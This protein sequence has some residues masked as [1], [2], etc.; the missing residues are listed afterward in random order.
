ML[1]LGSSCEGPL[2]TIHSHLCLSL[3]Y[4]LLFAVSPTAPSFSSQSCLKSWGQGEGSPD[5]VSLDFWLDVLRTVKA[6]PLRA[7]LF[8]S[9]SGAQLNLIFVP[10]H[11]LTSQ[12]LVIKSTLAYPLD[13]KSISRMCMVLELWTGETIIKSIVNHKISIHK[14]IIKKNVC[15]Q[16]IRM[17]RNGFFVFPFLV[18]LIR[19]VGSEEQGWGIIWGNCWHQIIY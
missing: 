18:W 1:V 15:F 3:T 2:D 10:R 12:I 13:S 14:R 5:W 4:Y 16:H 8:F 6:L 19:S 17:L 11:T 7:K 9:V